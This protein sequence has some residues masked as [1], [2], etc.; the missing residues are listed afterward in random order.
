MPD[1]QTAG[2]SM[3][4]CGRPL[5]TPAHLVTELPKPPRHFGIPGEPIECPE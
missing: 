2:M 5:I 1:N 3:C 4:G